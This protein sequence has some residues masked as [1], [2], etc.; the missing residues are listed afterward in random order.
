METARWANGIRCL[1]C[2]HGEIYKIREGRLYT[3]KTCRK[4]FTIRT[5]TVMEGS[6]IPIRKWL[7]GMYLLST[8]RKGISSIQLAKEIGITQKSAWFMLNRIRETCR[9]EGQVSGIVEVDETYIGGKEMN[10]HKNKKL[11]AGRG[12]IGKSVVFGARSRGGEIRADVLPDTGG[13]T[14][15]SAVARRVTAGSKLFSDDH[16][17]YQGIKGYYHESVNHSARE[18]VRGEVHTNSV[19]SAWAVIK[20]G[21]YGT[22]H[23]WSKKHLRR[24]IDEFIFRLNTKNLPAFDRN[25]ATCGINFIR[26]LVAGMEGRRLTYKS[27]IQ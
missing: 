10:K 21:H 27:L 11:N 5:G 19:E 20:R 25:E 12:T 8:S 14:I 13:K 3:C 23:Q 16:Q 1:H 9:Q 17:S 7:Y 6:H 2:G 18:Y 26:V 24:Y 22:F 4:Q 15:R